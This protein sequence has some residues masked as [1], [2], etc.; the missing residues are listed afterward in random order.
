[1]SGQIPAGEVAGGGG[2]ERGSTRRS[3]ATCGSLGEAWDGRNRATHGE[4]GRRPEAHGG[5]VVPACGEGEERAGEVQ[6]G[7]R[8]LLV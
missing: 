3:C 7:T 4:P 1:M 8:K 6:W 2:K 5:G